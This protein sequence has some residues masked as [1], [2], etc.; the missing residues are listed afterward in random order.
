[1]YYEEF[2]R[3]LNLH[4]G[5][6]KGRRHYLLYKDLVENPTW[7]EPP[8]LRLEEQSKGGYEEQTEE[9]HRLLVDAF[10]FEIPA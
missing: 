10:G 6:T 2:T 3:S 8:P 9:E 1:M 7:L 5:A 4:P